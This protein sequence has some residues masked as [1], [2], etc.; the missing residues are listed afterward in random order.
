MLR[1]PHQAVQCRGTIT[2]TFRT[3]T[4]HPWRHGAATL[5]FGGQIDLD[6]GHIQ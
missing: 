4:V 2:F 1:R 6:Q 3:T 5:W